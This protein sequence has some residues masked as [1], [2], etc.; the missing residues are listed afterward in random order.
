[1]QT[2]C[3]ARDQHTFQFPPVL[4]AELQLWTQTHTTHNPVAAQLPRYSDTYRITGSQNRRTT[5]SQN[6]R[7][8]RLQSET[9]RPDNTTDNQMARG[10]HKNRN[11][12]DLATSEPSSP[13]TASPGY[14]NTQIK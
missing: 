12:I 5:E 8:D 11:Q 10:K 9:R 4:G 6:H 3:S 1:M 7:K 14:P 2:H 13:T